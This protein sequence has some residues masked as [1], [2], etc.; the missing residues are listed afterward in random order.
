MTVWRPP[1]S[2]RVKVL[3]L[4]WRGEELL[5]AE[6]TSDA[7]EVKGV[8]PIGG[9]VEF[10]ETREQALQR[11]FQE[12]LGCGI[13]IAGPW[14]TIENLFEHEGFLGHEFV[15]AANIRLKDPSLYE[16]DEI[17]LIEHD[18]TIWMAR[19]FI[20]DA[21]PEGVALYPRG[22]ADQLEA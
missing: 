7:G 9:A 1:Q 10:G 17:R 19:W 21:L 4:V 16:R 5:A 14:L 18:R 12:E 11:E 13:T 15:F 3:G 2:I 6:V 20:P 22:L 8:R